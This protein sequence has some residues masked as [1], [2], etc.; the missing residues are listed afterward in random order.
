MISERNGILAEANLEVARTSLDI[1]LF[2]KFHREFKNKSPYSYHENLYS[3]TAKLPNC[4]FPFYFYDCACCSLWHDCLSHLHLYEKLFNHKTQL[5]CHF[6]LKVLV[7]FPS[8]WCSLH[9]LH[10]LAPIVLQYIVTCLFAQPEYE[11]FGSQEIRF[12]GFIHCSS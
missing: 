11:F 9:I 12:L 10:T 3:N 7:E 5:K 6:L 1:I 8:S 2:C 4:H